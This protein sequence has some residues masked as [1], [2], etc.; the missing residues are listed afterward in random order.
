MLRV[1]QAEA[2]TQALSSLSHMRIIKSNRLKQVN[3]WHKSIL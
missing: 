3:K 1:L 2:I